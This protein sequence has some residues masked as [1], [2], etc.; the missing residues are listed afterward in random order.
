MFRTIVFEFFVHR[1]NNDEQV[2]GYNDDPLIL[3][4]DQKYLYSL[5]VCTSL[6]LFF[7]NHSKLCFQNE[8]RFIHRSCPR[9]NRLDK[10]ELFRARDKRV[11]E[12]KIRS[13][14]SEMFTYSCFLWVLYVISYSNRDTNAFRQVNH[15]RNFLLNADDS[16]YDYRK[17]SIYFSL[18]QYRR[19][20]M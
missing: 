13:I 7:I 6:F 10:A 5:E 19:L 16:S 18:I 17:V 1:T 11:K 9:A 15:L 8:R 3:S 12:L 14:L 4:T 20:T 2:D